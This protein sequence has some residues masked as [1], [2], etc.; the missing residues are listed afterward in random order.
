MNNNSITKINALISAFSIFNIIWITL[1]QQILMLLSSAIIIF[2]QLLQILNLDLLE[3]LI[4][5]VL[6]L[7]DKVLIFEDFLESK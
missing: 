3:K 5:Q 2:N 6:H 7:V 1:T 4:Y